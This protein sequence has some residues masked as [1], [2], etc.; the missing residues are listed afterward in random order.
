M[1]TLSRPII[2]G[3][4]SLMA[5]VG[6]S[7]GSAFATN[8]HKTVG[9]VGYHTNEQLVIAGSQPTPTVGPGDHVVICHALGEENKD[10]YDQIAPSAGDVFGHAGQSHQ[11]GQDIIPPFIYEDNQEHTN[12][13]L[14][15]GQNWDATGIAI[16]NNGCVAPVVQEEKGSITVVKHLN[17]TT[18]T[19]LFNLSVGSTVVAS[20]VGHN[21][22]GTAHD[23]KAGNYLVSETAGTNTTMSNYG[24]LVSCTNGATGTTSTTVNLAAGQ[25]VTC[26]FTNT[27]GGQGGGGQTPDCDGDF[28]NS[29]SSECTPTGGQGSGTTTT[30]AST[31][32]GGA[33]SAAT[34]ATSGVNAGEGTEVTNVSAMAGM[35]ASVGALGLGVRR[36]R[37]T[38]L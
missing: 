35:L 27:R 26:T 14:Q 20:N 17:P 16:Y 12:S 7:A 13:S 6:L 19:G 23:L 28:D 29:P 22:Q 1:R 34:P 5:I 11:D 32:T 9:P 2:S 36:I 4:F 30:T 10:T 21:G 31:T 33:G 25:S 3:A 8:V 18:D 15:N 37:K 24:S 38:E